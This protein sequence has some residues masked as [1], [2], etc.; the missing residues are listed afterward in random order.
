MAR[1]VVEVGLLGEIEVVGGWMREKRLVKM[2]V[3][4]TGRVCLLEAQERQDRRGKFG[5]GINCSSR[6]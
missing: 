5:N 4:S 3:G 2:V 6:G 1:G